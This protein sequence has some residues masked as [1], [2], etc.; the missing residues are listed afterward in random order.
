MLLK[1]KYEEMDEFYQLLDTFIN[2]HKAITDETRDRK[3]RVLNR[4][5]QLYNNYFNAY[6]KKLQ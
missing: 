3:N 4:V 1:S 5:K 6:K 2:I